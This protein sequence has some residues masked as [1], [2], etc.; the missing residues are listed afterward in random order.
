MMLFSLPDPLVIRCSMSM[1]R[2]LLVSH[3]VDGLRLASLSEK[4]QDE[5]MLLV[6]ATPELYRC[7]ISM[8]GIRIHRNCTSS[9]VGWWGTKSSD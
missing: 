6:S 3:D 9:D 4:Q 1:D 2:V 7:N 8:H 5:S